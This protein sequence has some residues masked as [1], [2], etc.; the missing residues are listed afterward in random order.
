[1]RTRLSLL[2]IASL[3]LGLISLSPAA[4]SHTPNPEVLAITD[5][6]T[7]EVRLTFNS[8]IA[9]ASVRSY[10]ITATPN[11]PNSA[12]YSKTFTRK[13]SGYISQRITALT[14]GTDYKFRVSIRTTNNRMINSADFNFYTAST[15]PTVPV[16]TRAFETDSD[17]AVVYFDAPANDGQTPVLYYTA[18]ANPGN[19]TGITLQRGSGSITITGL[20]KSTTYTFT[21]TAH[22]INGTSVESKPS[23]PV[24]TL[25]NKIIRVAPASSSSGGSTLAAPAFTLSLAAETKTV[26]ILSTGYS[27][28]PTGG[29]IA[30]YSIS[31]DLPAGLSFSTSDGLI[32]GR[33][34]ETRTATTHTI[35]A[36][37]AT[38]SASNTY[39]LRVNG[40]I[41]DIGP[42]GGRIFYYSAAGFN[43][44]T[45]FTDTGS[46]TGEKC[47]YL[48]VAP[49]GWANGGTPTV[50]PTK[51]W[52]KSLVNAEYNQF[53]PGVTRQNSGWNTTA[54]V[55]LGYKDSLAIVA[56]DLGSDSTAGAAGF[57]RTYSGGDKSDWYLPSPV[58][59]NL[60]CQWARGVPSSITT[61]CTGGTLNSSTYGASAAGLTGGE[62]W[63]STQDS[64][65]ASYAVVLDF[66]GSQRTQQKFNTDS[67]RPIRAF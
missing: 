46:A 67:V 63:S 55:G 44:G 47:R 1:M 45:N 8:K 51:R 54:G 39:R 59:L 11:T 6:N 33:A 29:T 50:D 61:T 10:Q 32:T 64:S 40:D 53:V 20:T 56:N 48:E 9:R 58:E 52:S 37:N 25:A 2:V 38:G 28:T 57:A 66:G 42:G 5:G 7:G 15:R 16:I 12:S 34:T 22:N 4:N 62:Y 14:P 35:T 41:G 43:C 65:N 24:T 18:K 3:I 23:L 31:P 27:I 30:S 13:V 49:S 36:T 21:I 19:A 17:E 60:L 26:G